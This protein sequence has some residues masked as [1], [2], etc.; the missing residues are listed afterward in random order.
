[1]FPELSSALEWATAITLSLG[2]SFTD[3]FGPSSRFFPPYLAA[4]MTLAGVV[5]FVNR[6]RLRS[7]GAPDFWR[8]L[9]NPA[10]YFCQSSLVDLKV[11]LANRLLAPFLAVIRQAA[12]VIS[13]STVAGMILGAGATEAAALAAD[14]ATPGFATLAAVTLLITVASDFTTYWIHRFHHESAIFWP[15]H[16]L[17]H[18]AEQLTPLTV[19]RKHPV[20]DLTR[21][22]SNAFIVGPMQGLVF[23]LFGVTD[24]FVVLGVNA[25]YAIFNWTGSNLRHTNLWLSYGPFWSRIFISPAQHQIHH[26]LAVRHHNKNHG[27]LLALWDWIFG[28]LYVPDGYEALEFGVADEM[29]AALPQAHPTLKDAYL[30]PFKEAAAAIHENAASEPAQSET[31][32]AH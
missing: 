26:S 32:V 3:L 30:V 2:E 15:F 20:Y 24:V 9:L 18:S 27:E 16:K 11:V 8:S 5:Y 22:L 21:A 14:A 19:L 23:A 25:A 10:V 4:A 13:A 31:T 6:K 7:D 17:H 29:G 1:M 12:I 28:T